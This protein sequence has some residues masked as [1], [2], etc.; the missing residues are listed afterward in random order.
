MTFLE[1]DQKRKTV[2]EEAKAITDELL[3][4]TNPIGINTPLVD[5]EGYPRSDIDIYRARDLR[6]RLNE[7]NYDHRTIMKQIENHLMNSSNSANNNGSN[8]ASI[9]PTSA[10]VPASSSSGSNVK[11]NKDEDEELQKRRAPKPKPK[12]DAATGKWVVCNWDGS[13]A[14]VKNGHLRSFEHMNHNNNNNNENKKVAKVDTHENNN[15]SAISTTST[16]SIENTLASSCTIKEEGKV[17]NDTK[18]DDSDSSCFP[19][20]KIS[21]IYDTSPATSG[22]LQLHDSI[23][24]I[25]SIDWNNHQNLQ[26]VAGAVQG[27][28]LSGKTIRFLVDRQVASTQKTERMVKIVKPGYWKGDGV[29]GCRIVRI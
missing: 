24:K 9:S 15:T 28:F 7:L 1:L 8:S 14:G 4:G 18:T 13:I 12:F 20:A 10:S 16:Q 23:V 17:I 2:E 26:A 3:S 21:E 22:G 6:K 11:N 25:D 5:D 19:F 27:A 29:L